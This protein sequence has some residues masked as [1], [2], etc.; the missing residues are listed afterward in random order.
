MARSGCCNARL[1]S[2]RSFPRRRPA[3]ARH[4]SGLQRASHSSIALQMHGDTPQ[5]AQRRLRWPPFSPRK[6][7]CRVRCRTTPRS[8][9]IAK[10]QSESSIAITGLGPSRNAAAQAACGSGSSSRLVVPAHNSLRT[11]LVC[12]WDRAACWHFCLL[13]SNLGRGVWLEHPCLCCL[14]PEGMDEAEPSGSSASGDLLGTRGALAFFAAQGMAGPGDACPSPRHP[15]QKLCL[16]LQVSQAAGSQRAAS[17]VARLRLSVCV[18][19]ER[20]GDA[21]GLHHRR[22]TIDKQETCS[23][24]A[25]LQPPQGTP[26]LPALGRPPLSGAPALMPTLPHL[27]RALGAMSSGRRLVRKG[28][29]RMVGIQKAD[30]FCV[31]AWGGGSPSG[32]C[33]HPSPRSTQAQRGVCSGHATAATLEQGGG[34]SQTC[35]TA[36]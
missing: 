29:R 7:L 22:N 14:V 17:L 13:S 25:L 6:S 4:G 9:G 31:P 5:P 10:A 18:A 28:H 20:C 15:G 33:K 27:A 2:S 36:K 12:R 1:A 19:G 8:A 30:A 11:G 26:C 34:G 23:F 16:R 24:P 32:T 35:S 21:P 3:P